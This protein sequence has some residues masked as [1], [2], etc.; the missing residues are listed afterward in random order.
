M[1]AAGVPLAG[2][3]LQDWCGA[4]ITDAGKQLWWDWRLDT[5]YYPG[6]DALAAEVAALGGRMLVYINPYL[7]R[8]PGHDT[9]YR[10]ALAQGYLVQEQDGTPFLRPQHQLRR[11]GGRSQ[12]TR[13]RGPGSRA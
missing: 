2:L 7:C 1:K 13:R 11:G 9:L 10:Q 8:Q 3:W 6:W 4:R 12:R 5:G